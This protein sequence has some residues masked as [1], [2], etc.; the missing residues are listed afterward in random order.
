MKLVP[1]LA[2]YSLDPSVC[3]YKLMIVCDY[4]VHDSPELAKSKTTPVLVPVA[5]N[6]DG[7]ADPL[8]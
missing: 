2:F 5:V 1:I 7:A 6:H 4:A 8:L 3:I